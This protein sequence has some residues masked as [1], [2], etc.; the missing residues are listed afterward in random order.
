MRLARAAL[1]L[2]VFNLFA[3]RPKLC[4][5]AA[6]KGGG[7]IQ[8]AQH[9]YKTFVIQ[10]KSSKLLDDLGAAH[11]ADQLII[12]AAQEV[13]YPALLAS[14]LA[15]NDDLI[16]LFPLMHKGGDQF[17]RILKVGAEHY[18]TIAGSLQNSVIWAVELPKVLDIKNRLDLFILAADLL[19]N[20]S[21]IIC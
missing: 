13:H 6:D 11:F 16:A 9:L 2:G 18:G 3:L 21:R 8:L 1:W 4:H 7:I 19:K 17:D 20:L 14:C 10:S 5:N 15:A 12:A